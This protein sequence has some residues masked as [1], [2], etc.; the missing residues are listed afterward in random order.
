MA[1]VKNIFRIGLFSSLILAIALSSAE[2]AIRLHPSTDVKNRILSKRLHC[3]GPEGTW[4]TLCKNQ[5][6]E[7]LL[8]RIHRVSTDGNGERITQSYSLSGAGLPAHEPYDE[9]WMLGDS[10]VMG[11]GLNDEESLPYQIHKKSGLR[12]RNLAVDGLGSG[13]ILLRWKRAMDKLYPA[14]NRTGDIDLN[15]SKRYGKRI[16]AYWIFHPSDFVDDPIYRKRSHSF[17][18]RLAWK[19]H[20]YLSRYSYLYNQLLQLTSPRNPQL[21]AIPANNKEVDITKSITATYINELIRE[22]Q[23]NKVPLT[24]LLYPDIDSHSGK[25]DLTHD[26]LRTQIARAIAKMGG[27]V[28]DLSIDFRKKSENPSVD[29]LYIAGDGH[30]DK[31]AVAIFTNAI[32]KDL[33]NQPSIRARPWNDKKKNGG[34]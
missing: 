8:P 25:P 6:I 3:L 17:Y 9:V 20:F 24:I 21:Q 11:Y 27:R 26:A 2:M 19:V 34:L 1:S 18:R 30:P 5:K 12:V 29:P 32:L 33:S 7:L 4:V 31:G 22:T 16:I 14:H 28:I 23:A 10:I 15:N 13:S